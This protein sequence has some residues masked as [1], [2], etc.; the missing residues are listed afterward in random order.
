MNSRFWPI[1]KILAFQDPE[2]KILI[3][4]KTLAFQYPEFQILSDFKILAFQNPEFQILAEFLR[5]RYWLI[6]KF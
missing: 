4:F 6:S 1:L 3:D 2:F 5:S